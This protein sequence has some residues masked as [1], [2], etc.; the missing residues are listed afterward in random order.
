MTTWQHEKRRM[1]KKLNDKIKLSNNYQFKEKLISV[2]NIKSIYYFFT[3]KVEKYINL[4]NT[5][6]IKWFMLLVLPLYFKVKNIFGASYVASHSVEDAPKQ[7]PQ[8]LNLSQI[9]LMCI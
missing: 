5:K 9:N 2:L 6:I 8:I 4:T 3:F 7:P 1:N